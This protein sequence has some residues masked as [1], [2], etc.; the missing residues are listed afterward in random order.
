M[1]IE[2]SELGE[3]IDQPLRTYSSGMTV[4]LGFSVVAHLDPEILLVDEVLAVGDINFPFIYINIFFN[5]RFYFKHVAIS[6]FI[7]TY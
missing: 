3:F 2:F 1:I 5:F 6:T 4:R 7:Y